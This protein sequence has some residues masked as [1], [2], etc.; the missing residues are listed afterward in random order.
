V[1]FRGLTNDAIERTLRTRTE[2]A[3][4]RAAELAR[5]SGGRLGWAIAAMHDERMMEQRERALERA[6]ALA[7]GPLSDR[8]AYAAEL[9][10]GYTKERAA[11]QA[12]LETWQEWWRDILVIAA[13]RESQAVNRD[14]GGPCAASDHRCAAAARGECQSGVG[15]RGD[16]AGA[17]GTPTERRL[18][19]AG[20]RLRR[21]DPRAR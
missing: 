19:A 1:G 2:I 21:K 20:R 15:A 8:M 7:Q 9:G 13:G 3:P 14:C 6:E 4:E 5:L 11:V 16:D 18:P 12:V 17:A 10:G